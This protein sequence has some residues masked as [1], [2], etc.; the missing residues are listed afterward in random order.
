[1]AATAYAAERTCTFAPTAGAEFKEE[2]KEEAKEDWSECRSR[3]GSEFEDLLPSPIATTCALVVLSLVIFTAGELVAWIWSGSPELRLLSDFRALVFAYPLV[4]PLACLMVLGQTAG[5]I[6][7]LA[8][9]VYPQLFFALNASTLP[10]LAMAAMSMVAGVPNF[11]KGDAERPEL[12][13][14]TGY[15]SDMSKPFAR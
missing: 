2:A 9:L 15:M 12:Q 7:G 8:M 11:R 4:V 14:L 6:A 13:L 10:P 3:A 1:M 5:G